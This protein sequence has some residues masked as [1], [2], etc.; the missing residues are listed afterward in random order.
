MPPLHSTLAVTDALAARAA[1]GWV[2]VTLPV[3]EQPLL[4]LT[5]KVYVPAVAVML[6]VVAL[7]L[8]EYV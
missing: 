7:L 2:M 6:D 4:S 8:H 3:E 1:A 5:V